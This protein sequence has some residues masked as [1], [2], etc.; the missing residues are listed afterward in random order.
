MGEK[1]VTFPAE[2]VTRLKLN[3]DSCQ[4]SIDEKNRIVCAEPGERRT[5]YG[6]RYDI[7]GTSGGGCPLRDYFPTMPHLVANCG[8]VLSD[9]DKDSTNDH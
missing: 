6:C 9:V 7:P 2:W 8:I 1:I 3:R 5:E 4:V